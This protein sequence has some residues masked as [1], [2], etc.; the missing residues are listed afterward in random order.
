[1]ALLL[2]LMACTGD[3]TPLD[4]NGETVTLRLVNP[5][6]ADPFNIVDRLVLSLV[7]DGEVVAT[8][9][10]SWDEDLVT[11]PLQEYGLVRF[12]LMGTGAGK[13][14]SYG[15]TPEVLVGPGQELDLPLLFLPVNQAFPLVTE[16]T[17]P[18]SE[19]ATWV[20]PDGRVLL[21]GG[22]N[23]TGTSAFA[24]LSAYDPATGL[25]ESVGASLITGLIHPR[26]DA[27][28]DKLFIVGGELPGGGSSD[29][30]ALYDPVSGVARTQ[31]SLSHGR[32]GHC[33]KIFRSGFGLAV[34]GNVD[35]RVADYLRPQADS[36]DW[37]WTE[38]L[39][40]PLNSA[41]V[42][43]CA[44]TS[45][46][47]IFIQGEA[48]DSTGLFDYSAEAAASLPSVADAFTPA[49]TEA[50]SDPQYVRGAMVVP[51]P[52]G[53]A[54]IGGGE[55]VDQS[56][57]ATSARRFDQGTL[58]FSPTTDPELPRVNGHWGRWIEQGWAALGCG[59]SDSFG[60][61]QTGVELI[62][63]V[64]GARGDVIELDRDRPGCAMTVL[65][66]GALLITGGFSESETGAGAALI[67]PYPWSTD[68][69]E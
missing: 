64:S 48:A 68:L 32:A 47:R 5:T 4:T 6:E 10:A 23:A 59:D 39:L 25:F 20:M 65:P 9:E 62:D 1:M 38:V 52:D 29:S 61:P 41:G 16:L 2:L 34:G 3:P 50:A 33:F 27:A 14:R 17:Q 49:S 63:L 28:E 66:D 36:G 22:R 18:R 30:V 51:L 42:T 44:N 31:T 21:V 35:Y 67:V 54:W 24:E 40:D 53:D 55:L 15:R 56:R 11:P 45:E 26:V 69:P 19:H 7:V 37:D 43:G 12:E 57:A 60:T 46:G 8:H 13:I 58:S